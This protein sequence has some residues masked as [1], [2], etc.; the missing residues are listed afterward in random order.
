MTKKYKTTLILTI[1]TPVLLAIV[2]LLTGGGHG[3]Y[4]P[5]IV[6]FPTSLVSFSIF[7][8]LEFPFVVL[9]IIQYPIYGFIIDRLTNKQKA[10]LTIFT[11]HIVLVII[12]FL[13]TKNM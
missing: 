2:V 11:V 3:Y 1:L 7:G 8:R 10:T 9:G 4:S 12:T 13:T 6:L 5:G